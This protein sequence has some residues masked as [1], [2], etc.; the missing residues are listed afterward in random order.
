MKQKLVLFIFLMSALSLNAQNKLGSDNATTFEYATISARV[1]F[2]S[3]SIVYDEK[4]FEK[5]PMLHLP[6]GER[7]ILKNTSSKS[8]D[9]RFRTMNE[10]INYMSN[11]GWRFVSSTVIQNKFDHQEHVQNSQINA[12]NADNFLQQIIFEREKK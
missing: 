8:I 11:E 12:E 10:L 1:T 3:N 9:N 6:S 2:Q 5:S 4:S 7:L